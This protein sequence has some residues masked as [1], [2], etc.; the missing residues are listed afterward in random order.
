LSPF[1]VAFLSSLGRSILSMRR[2]SPALIR[3]EVDPSD[4]RRRPRNRR[5]AMLHRSLRRSPL[6][7]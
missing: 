2:S 3:L 4:D 6:A 7:D 5:R 1:V